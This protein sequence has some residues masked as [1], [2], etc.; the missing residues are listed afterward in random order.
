MGMLLLAAI[1]GGRVLLDAPRGRIETKGDGSPV[2]FADLMSERAIAA[3]LHQF[4]PGLPVVSEEGAKTLPEGGAET[5]LLVDPL[6]GT[7]EFIAGRD[8][9]AVCIAIV[10]SGRPAA[11]VILAPERRL[12][13]LAD[14]VAIELPLD[15]ALIPVPERG[16]VLKAGQDLSEGKHRIVV[17]RS[18]GDPGAAAICAGF[19]GWQV[20][21]L[22]SAI[23]FAAVA[24]GDACLYPRGAGSME[25]DT[26]A[27][28][29]LVHAAGGVLRTAEGALKIYGKTEEGFRNGPFIAARDSAVLARALAQWPAN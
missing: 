19:P 22:G 15:E 14:G 23:K 4:W 6:D 2:T 27:G 5:F 3:K 21:D 10:E 18:H 1:A 26:A 8:D 28:D 13:W 17:S 20:D 25:W 9:F 12:A 16:R 11:G 24:R 29:A 7:R